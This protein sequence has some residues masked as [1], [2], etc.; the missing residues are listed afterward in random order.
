MG[1][2]QASAV[3]D[4]SEPERGRTSGCSGRFGFEG[5]FTGAP[6]THAAAQST[7]T[8][9][10]FLSS[11]QKKSVSDEPRRHRQADQ[12]EQVGY[13]GNT[14]AVACIETVSQG[15]AKCFFVESLSVR[16]PRRDT[17]RTIIIY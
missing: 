14:S 5:A 10:I 2:V 15:N 1:M 11:S 12:H 16:G 7:A 3:H 4:A 13:A 8:I 6:V 9:D 17:H